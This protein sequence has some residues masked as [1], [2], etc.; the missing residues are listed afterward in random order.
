MIIFL[1]TTPIPSQYIKYIFRL[2]I[3]NTFS[4][5]NVWALPLI[6]LK[7]KYV[8]LFLLKQDL[9]QSEIRSEIFTEAATGKHLCWNFFYLIKRL[10]RKYF[11]VDFAK[12]LRTIFLTEHLYKTALPLLTKYKFYLLL[13]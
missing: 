2:N 6:N 8:F 7:Y 10:Q 1:K 3:S 13:Y 12:V 11:P 9:W 4:L 5:S